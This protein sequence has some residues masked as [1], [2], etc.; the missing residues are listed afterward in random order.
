[1]HFNSVFSHKK[2]VVVPNLVLYGEET[3]TFNFALPT[4]NQ[5]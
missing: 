4:E 5:L 2:Y 1:M 3:V